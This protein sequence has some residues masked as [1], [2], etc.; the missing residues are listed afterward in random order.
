MTTLIAASNNVRLLKF[1]D[2]YEVWTCPVWGTD[3]A[4]SGRTYRDLGNAVSAA[5]ARAMG[6]GQNLDI[7]KSAKAEPVE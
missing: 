5:K 2:V 6:F 3:F 4:R 1:G 7:D